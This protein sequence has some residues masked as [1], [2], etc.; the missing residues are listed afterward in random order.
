MVALIGIAI[1]KNFKGLNN[2]ELTLV[3]FPARFNI[4]D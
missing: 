3:I 1:V 2:K 4:V